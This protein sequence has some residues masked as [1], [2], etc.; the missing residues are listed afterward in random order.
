[1]LKSIRIVLVETTHAGN[2]GAV[3]RAMKNMGLDQLCLVKPLHFPADEAYRR[4]SGAHDVLTKASVVGS[5]EEA[6]ADCVWVLGASARART[7]P[8]PVGSPRELMPE[9]EDKAVQGQVAVVFG[10]ENSG[11]TNDEL[12]RC[13]RHLHIPCNPSFASLN[14]AMAVQVF[15][16]EVFQQYLSSK[17]GVLDQQDF[18]DAAAI[19]L[20]DA[21]R[22]G[23]MLG[24]QDQGWDEQPATAGQLEKLFVHLEQALIDIGFHNPQQPR[25]LMPRLRRL[26]Q[27]VQLDNMEINILRGILKAAQTSAATAATARTVAASTKS[28]PPT[29]AADKR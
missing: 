10:R 14:V 21:S 6:V 5:L 26:L 12:Q 2:I 27:R 9:L 11:L 28:T 4:S 20:K 19:Q 25:Q 22:L 13:H 8:W 24:P 18:E 7:L 3:A 23:N 1:M 29:P 17:Q 16:Y 15:C